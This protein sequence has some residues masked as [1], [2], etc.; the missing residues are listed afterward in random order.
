M[1]AAIL[2]QSLGDDHRF[3]AAV[4]ES[5]FVSFRQVADIRVGQ[6]THT[7]PWFGET[8]ARPIINAAFGYVRFR[9]GVDLQRANPIEGIT[10]TCTPVLLIHGLADSNIPPSSSIELH[11]AALDTTELW[12]VRGAGHCGASAVAKEQFDNSVLSWFGA[13]DHPCS[14]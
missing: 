8:F 7:G 3:C 5:S 13:H 1:G 14:T 4:A 2:L 12:L 10:R 6:F 9:Y 11:D